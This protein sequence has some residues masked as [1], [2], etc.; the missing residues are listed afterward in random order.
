MSSL[1]SLNR[2]TLVKMSLV[3]R[4]LVILASVLLA[5]AMSAVSAEIVS[6]EGQKFTV[7]L[8]LDGDPV[9][10]GRQLARVNIIDGDGKPVTNAEVKLSYG[11]KPSEESPGMNFITSARPQGEH[12][13]ATIDLS[14]EGQWNFKVN[15]VT[16]G[17]IDEKISITVNVK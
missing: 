3:K 13:A 11:K 12:Y 2:M 17:G 4:L 7:Q 15:V 8:N 6:S 9:T 1:S 5:T 10:P 16:A 14:S